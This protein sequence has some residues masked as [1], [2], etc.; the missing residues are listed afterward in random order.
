MAT[1]RTTI[2]A[3]LSEML[4]MLVRI[5]MPEA[6]RSMWEGREGA[7]DHVD[8]LR[9][10][11]IRLRLTGELPEHLCVK[12]L[13][14]CDQREAVLQASPTQ[15]TTSLFKPTGDLSDVRDRYARHRDPRHRDPRHDPRSRA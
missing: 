8:A 4:E 11:T 2:N 9:A 3:D 1:S 7:Q 6:L 10:E 13:D 5:S 15:A 12:V 14:R